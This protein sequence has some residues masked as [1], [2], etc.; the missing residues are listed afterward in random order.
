MAESCVV[1]KSL[2]K[3]SLKV[4]TREITL[5]TIGCCFHLVEKKMSV[6]F[7]DLKGMATVAA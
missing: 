5:S 1:N 4:H 6:P 7:A 2:Q 3:L